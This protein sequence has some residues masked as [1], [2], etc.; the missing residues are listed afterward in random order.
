MIDSYL[1]LFH[2]KLNYLESLNINIYNNL[3]KF[4]KAL[5]IYILFQN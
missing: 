2:N 4:L 5:I 3:L 1:I